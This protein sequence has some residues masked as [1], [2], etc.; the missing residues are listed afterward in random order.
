MDLMKM[1]KQAQ[2]MQ[3]RLAGALGRHESNGLFRCWNAGLA[4]KDR[5]FERAA[6]GYFEAVEFSQ[7]KSMA[8]T[9]LMRS[10]F[11]LAEQARV[12]KR[13][14][15]AD[16][17][18]LDAAKAG[19]R[20]EGLARQARFWT[21]AEE[22]GRAVRAWQMILADETLRDGQLLDGHGDPQQAGNVA[23]AQIA[24]LIRRQGAGV[25]E[26]EENRARQLLDTPEKG[27][28]R[29]AAAWAASV[30]PNPSAPSVVPARP[31]LA[32]AKK[33][34]RESSMFM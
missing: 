27:P 20:L 30:S 10:L 2:E 17:F 32:P 22:P 11:A 6:R 34:R 33:W 26:A 3:E 29:A 24:E 9:G 28:P 16:V 18:L 31:A 5:D 15:E 12:Q 4:F 13:L 7:V 21:A 8:R 1:M 14:E 23:T 25:Y 19:P